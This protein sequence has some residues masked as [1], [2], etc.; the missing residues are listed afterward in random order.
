MSARQKK[1]AQGDRI[2]EVSN[3]WDGSQRSVPNLKGL[4]AMGLFFFGG[5][6][7]DE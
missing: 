1:R 4:R 6:G 2:H 5:C 3:R 7:R